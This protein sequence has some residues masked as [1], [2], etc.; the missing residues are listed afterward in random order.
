MDKAG[1]LQKK[2]K[3]LSPCTLGVL[4]SQ[5]FSSVQKVNLSLRQHLRR[6]SLR[7]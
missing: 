6:S 5:G 4:L 1:G 2:E 3:V 7:H